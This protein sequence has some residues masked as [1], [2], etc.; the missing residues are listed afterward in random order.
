MFSKSVMA[1]TSLF[2]K[3]MLP[4]GEAGKIESAVLL[5]E[6]LRPESWLSHVRGLKLDGTRRPLR[7]LVQDTEV[8]WEESEQALLLS[9]TLPAG[10]FAT[11]L[12]DQVMGPVELDED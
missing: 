8:I 5:S 7:I 4:G 10:A 6:G 3:M 12:L 2:R 11:V 1:R 9:F